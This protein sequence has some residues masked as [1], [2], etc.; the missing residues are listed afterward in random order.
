MRAMA[1]AAWSWVEKMLQEA[2]RTEAPSFDEGLDEHRGL[3]R[4]VQ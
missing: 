4:H 3:D 2:Q 1:A